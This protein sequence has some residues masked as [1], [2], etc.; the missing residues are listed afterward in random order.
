MGHRES[1]SRI[2]K[3]VPSAVSTVGGVSLRHC[4]LLQ[5]ALQR[6]DHMLH[7]PSSCSRVVLLS[8]HTVFRPS[9]PIKAPETPLPVMEGPFGTETSV[10]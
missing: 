2:H 4:V 10:I 7:I 8:C 3:E 6:E 5:E 9:Q 1:S